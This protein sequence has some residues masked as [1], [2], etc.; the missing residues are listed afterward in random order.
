[1]RFSQRIR[2]WAVYR[3]AFT[4][5]L[6]LNRVPRQAAQTIGAWLG[7]VAWSVLPTH[8]HKSIRHLR[9]VYGD[10]LDQRGAAGIARRFFIN[11]GKNLADFVRFREHFRDELAPLV[12]IEGLEHYRCAF[13]AG[14]GVI[15]VTGHIGNFEVL[16]ARLAMEPHPVAVIARQLYDPRLHELLVGIR[17][18]VGLKNVLTT[19]SPRVLLGWL[20]KNGVVGVLIDTDSFR[21]R[22]EFIDWFGR[23][24]WTPI[25]QAL[26]GLRVGSAF[27]P[28]ACVRRPDDGYHIIIREQVR[29][30]PTGDAEADAIRITEACVRE[31]ETIIDAYRDQW[32]WLHNRWRTRPPA[33]ES[34]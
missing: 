30:E 9:L 28:L 2:R 24:A 1:M 19:D 8:R 32:I 26:L 31:L 23:P 4:C 7:L 29:V 27:V 5:L 3:L 21:V 16:A 11:S 13:Q 22:S 12:S 34:S 14:K 10:T 33:E 15:G 6:V 18:A 17:E 25:G 20:K